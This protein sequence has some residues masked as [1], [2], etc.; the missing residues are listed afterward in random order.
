MRDQNDIKIRSRGEGYSLSIDNC[1][2]GCYHL[3][4]VKTR[5]PG[6]SI[7]PGETDPYMEVT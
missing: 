6:L 7:E 1:F 2:A 5:S 3:A 4:C